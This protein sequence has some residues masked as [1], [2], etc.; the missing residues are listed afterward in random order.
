MLA[1]NKIVPSNTPQDIKDEEYLE[2]RYITDDASPE[3]PDNR[4]IMDSANHNKDRNRRSNEHD[5]SEFY[6]LQ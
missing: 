4:L 1:Q 2:P 6:E 5:I 3:A